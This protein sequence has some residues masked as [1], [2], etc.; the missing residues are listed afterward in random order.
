MKLQSDQISKLIKTLGE[1]DKWKQEVTVVFQNEE[2]EK[3]NYKRYREQYRSLIVRSSV[4][5][6]EL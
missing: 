6:I 2:I 1:I 3:L 5:Q 4:F